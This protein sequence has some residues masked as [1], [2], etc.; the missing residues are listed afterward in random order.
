MALQKQDIV[1]T[2][3]SVAVHRKEAF[4]IG[5]KDYF[6]SLK[7]NRI[8]AILNNSERNIKFDSISYRQLNSWDKEGLLT[9]VREGR[10]WRKFSIMDA[11]WVKIIQEMREFGMSWEQISNA[12][13]SLELESELYGVPMPILEFYT[14]FAIG[15]KM[16]VLILVFKDGICVPANFTQYKV[17]REFSRVDNHLQINLNNILQGFFPNVDLKP[18]NKLETNIGLDEMELLAFIRIGE[19]EKIEIQFGNGKMQTVEGTQRLDANQILSAVINEHKFQKIEVIVA[20]GKKVKLIRK[21][22]KEL[23]KK[24]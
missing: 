17:A 1:A 12:K 6:K 8:S 20:D 5:Y 14:A 2:N 21:V 15:S 16:P 23:N 9:A 18:I 7:T 24:G 11:I 4:D 10:E 3:S 22:K 13:K 19:Y